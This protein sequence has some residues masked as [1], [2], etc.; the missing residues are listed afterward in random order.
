MALLGHDGCAARAPLARQAA[1]APNEAEELGLLGA[2]PA[3]CAADALDASQAPV[4]GMRTLAQYL[5]KSSDRSGEAQ[6]GGRRLEAGGEVSR[7]E[8][9]ALLGRAAGVGHLVAQQLG[10]VQVD[11]RAVVTL[12]PQLGQLGRL[13]LQPDGM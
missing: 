13:L 12:N 1:C 9:E 3:G 5:G 6:V 7:G 8:L 10:A 2:T 11:H 4:A